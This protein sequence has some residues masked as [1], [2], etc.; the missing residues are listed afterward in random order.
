MHNPTQNSELIYHWLKLI[1]TYIYEHEHEYIEWEYRLP[2]TKAMWSR[3]RWFDTEFHAEDYNDI[4]RVWRLESTV[5]SGQQQRNIKFALPILGLDGLLTQSVIGKVF[6]RHDAVMKSMREYDVHINKN[7]IIAAQSEIPLVAFYTWLFESL[8]P[9]DACHPST[10]SLYLNERL[11]IV[12]SV[13][14]NKFQWYLNQ[15]PKHHYHKIKLII[16]FAKR[17]PFVSAS[18]C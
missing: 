4:K 16:A 12:K 15:D 17:R 11:L 18:M 14:R 13:A 2:C 5:Y 8:M 9:R 7:N 6:P 1:N 10:S 3:F